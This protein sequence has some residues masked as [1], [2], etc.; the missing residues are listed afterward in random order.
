MFVIDDRDRMQ[1]LVEAPVGEQ[2]EK[3][4]AAVRRCPR[5]ALSLVDT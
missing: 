2:V 5:R 4:R 3:A 1:L